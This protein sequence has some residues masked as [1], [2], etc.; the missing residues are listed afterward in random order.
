MIVVLSDPVIAHKVLTLNGHDKIKSA[1]KA[2]DFEWDNQQV[3]AFVEEGSERKTK[4][5]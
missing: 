1:G 5:R 4:K 2:R 3:N